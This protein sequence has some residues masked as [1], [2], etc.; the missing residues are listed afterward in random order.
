MGEPKKL[1][2]WSDDPE[3]RAWRREQMELSNDIAGLPRDP[4]VDALMARL[5]LMLLSDEEKILA[6]KQYFTDLAAAQ[7]AQSLLSKT[8]R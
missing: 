5:D 7:H 6:L 2:M 8:Q 4:E 3:S 1:S